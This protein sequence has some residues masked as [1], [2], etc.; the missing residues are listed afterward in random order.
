L[1][2]LAQESGDE[3]VAVDG[4]ARAAWWRLERGKPDEAAYFY[5]TAIAVAAVSSL[6]AEERRTDEVFVKALASALIQ[7]S[8]DLIRAGE[9]LERAQ[10]DVLYALVVDEVDKRASDL[11]EIVRSLL[12]DA[13]KAYRGDTEASSA[14]SSSN[15][16]S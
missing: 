13:V 11:G 8:A 15:E 2:D 6:P 16:G 5:A 14:N 10:A 7:P 12:E 1:V 9:T 3:E 4:L